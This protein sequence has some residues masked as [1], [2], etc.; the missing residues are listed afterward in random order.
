[1]R[2]RTKL[3]HEDRVLHQAHP[4]HQHTESYTARQLGHTSQNPQGSKCRSLRGA[5]WP[6]MVVDEDPVEAKG[7][8]TLG[9]VERSLRGGLEG[10]E[11][12]SYLHPSRSRASKAAPIAPEI[13]PNCDFTTV[14]GGRAEDP[15]TKDSK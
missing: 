6:Q 7:L 2:Q 13:S 1:M 8:R 12:D 4:G 15:S 14:M 9:Y 5:D 11:K 10:R 3:P